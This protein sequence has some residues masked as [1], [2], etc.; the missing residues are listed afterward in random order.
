MEKFIKWLSGICAE[1]HLS[2]RHL[3][4]VGLRER[5]EREREERERDGY[6]GNLS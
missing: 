3:H 6:I 2:E 1:Q 4:E 5:R